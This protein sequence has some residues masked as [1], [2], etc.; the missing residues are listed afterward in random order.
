MT[1]SSFSY[2]YEPEHFKL[3]PIE[4]VWQDSTNH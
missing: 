2:T 1:L 4:K 3:R